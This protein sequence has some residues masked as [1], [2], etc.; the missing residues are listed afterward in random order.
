MNFEIFGL[1]KF[2]KFIN[3]NKRKMFIDGLK[4]GEI[5]VV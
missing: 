4:H 1:L 5:S 3:I 2:I